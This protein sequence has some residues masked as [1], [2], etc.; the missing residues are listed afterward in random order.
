MPHR[1][2]NRSRLHS[3]PLVCKKNMASGI[4]VS[5][6]SRDNSLLCKCVDDSKTAVFRDGGHKF[7]IGG[8][9][10]VCRCVGHKFPSIPASYNN[11]GSLPTRLRLDTFQWLT[12]FFADFS[13]S[14]LPTEVAAAALT[15]CH[16]G[17]VTNILSKGFHSP[18]LSSKS[19][20]G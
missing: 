19:S 9:Y 10:K 20:C 16:D 14:P 8:E 4:I 11:R 7:D 6:V 13:F 5:N 15:G 2:Q 17:I 3:N 12:G 18:T 1:S